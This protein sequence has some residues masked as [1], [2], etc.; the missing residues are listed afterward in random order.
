MALAGVVPGMSVVYNGD[1]HTEMNDSR[2]RDR[3]YLVEVLLP[4]YDNDGEP[5]QRAMFDEVR[6]E[7]ADRFGGVTA[8]VRA[9]AEGLWKQGGGSV[10][11]DD[12][13]LF[14]VMTGQLD[15]EWWAEY[16]MMLRTRFE[17]DEL[18]VRASV[19]QRL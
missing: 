17:Q 4:V 7:L 15:H 13:V 14:E 2:E 1:R 9:P 10:V 11:R 5:F 8:F 18:V 3:M 19:V 6:R 12:I 16:R